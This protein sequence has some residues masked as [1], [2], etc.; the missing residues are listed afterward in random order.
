MDKFHLA[1]LIGLELRLVRVV[2]L[3]HVF[4]VDFDILIKI[5]GVKSNDVHVKFV[6]AALKIFVEL[7]FGY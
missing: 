2:I 5:A 4:I 7:A 6:V 3:L 1:F